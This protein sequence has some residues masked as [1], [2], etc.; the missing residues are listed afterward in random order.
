MAVVIN[1]EFAR[2]TV[3]VN[4][5]DD[6]DDVSFWELTLKPKGEREEKSFSFSISAAEAFYFSEAMALLIKEDF[7]GLTN[8]DITR[9]LTR[10]KSRINFEQSISG[11]FSLDEGVYFQ[12]HEGAHKQAE[13]EAPVFISLPQK[14][15]DLLTI[16]RLQTA[17][18]DFM[19][20]MGFEMKAQ[21]EPV[22]GSFFQKLVFFLEG[23]GKDEAVDIY[24][25]G[26]DALE[27]QYIDGPS[28]EATSKLATAAAALITALGPVDEGALRLG[29]ILVVKVTQNGLSRIMA[30]TVSHEVIKLLDSNPVLLENPQALF[31]MLTALKGTSKQLN[32]SGASEALL[33]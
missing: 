8:D 23:K 1:L 25:K 26:K 5:L 33:E 24:K 17:T 27:M 18:G 29:G 13:T 2:V 10:A 28:A 21:S 6:G 4:R 9:F 7:N 22:L 14:E 19:E 3:T 11:A 20:A 31:A 16:E 12:R 32:E 30:E 15:I